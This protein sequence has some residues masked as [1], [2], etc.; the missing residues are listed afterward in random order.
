MTPEKLR[1]NIRIAAIQFTEEVSAIFG[2]AFASVAAE[3]KS[4]PMEPRTT[5]KKPSFSSPSPVRGPARPDKRNRRSIKELENV[6][7]EVIKLL[8]KSKKQMRIE[9]IN[10]E[11]G[12]NTRQLM[13]P[14]QKLLNQ[15]RIKK[16]GERRATVYF[17]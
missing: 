2:E 7:G 11:L 8:Q 17:I 1:E 16:D 3:F 12:T 14:I 15:G 10:K 13:R 9:E 4:G 5:V 6:G